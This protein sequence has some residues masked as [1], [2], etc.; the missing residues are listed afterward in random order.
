MRKKTTNIF[1]LSIV[2]GICLIAGIF[3]ACAKNLLDG[4]KLD[5]PDTAIE[6]ELGS[7]SLPSYHVVTADGA[8][9]SGY[10]VS[11]V[12]AKYKDGK[13]IAISYGSINVNTPATVEVV[14]ETDAEGVSAKTLTIEFD[15]RIAPALNFSGSFPQYYC[16]TVSYEIP[17]FT[18]DGNYDSAKTEYAIYCVD[19]EDANL[20]GAIPLWE[21]D[22]ALRFT[23]RPEDLHKFYA[24]T[25]HLEDE[26]GNTTN[27]VKMV[28]VN[29]PEV[30]DDN[31]LIYLEDPFGIN[32]VSDT[33]RGESILE[34]VSAS[35]AENYVDADKNEVNMQQVLSSKGIKGATKFTRNG[36]EEAFWT[37]TTPTIIDMGDNEYV[38]M[39]IYNPN[40]QALRLEHVRGTWYRLAPK[41]WTRVIMSKEQV[42]GVTDDNGTPQ[43]LTNTKF[44]VWD[45]E[46]GESIYL[47]N[48][49]LSKTLPVAVLNTGDA[50][51]ADSIIDTVHNATIASYVTTEDTYAAAALKAMGISGAVKV[52]SNVTS[53]QKG[54]TF[55]TLIRG[56]TTSMVNPITAGSGG[57][58]SYYG[59][60]YFDVYNPT[61]H[62]ATIDLV[63]KH[64]PV[65]LKSQEWTRVIY[66][67][68]DVD[69]VTD[70][71]G[72][73]DSLI[74][75]PD[76]KGCIKFC[77]EGLV[78]SESLYVSNFYLSDVNPMPVAWVD[79]GYE[80]ILI[81]GEKYDL[82]EYTSFG[83]T[84]DLHMYYLADR[85]AEPVD[86]SDIIRGSKFTVQDEHTSGIYRFVI[87]YT[88]AGE[89]Y[90][91]MRESEVV[92]SAPETLQGEG[93]LSK[94]VAD[95][96]TTFSVAA[97]KING[98]I[99]SITNQL[100]EV[101]SATQSEQD[102]KVVFTLGADD[103][104][105]IG[106]GD[107]ASVYV[108]T[109]KDG[110]KYT[111]IIKLTVWEDYITDANGLIAFE[112]A[113]NQATSA[114]APFTGWY[115]LASDID[116]TGIDH[117]FGDAAG[118]PDQKENLRYFA[119]VFD[120]CGYKIT[121]LKTGNRGLFNMVT[122]V[123]VIKNLAIVDAYA[124]GYNANGTAT[125]KNVSHG[126]NILAEKMEGTLE[127]LYVSGSVGSA[128]WSYSGL[129][130]QMRAE[131]I[132]N[133]IFK[134][135]L[136]GNVGDVDSEMGAWVQN[137]IAVCENVYI[138]SYGNKTFPSGLSDSR[139][140]IFAN[141][142]EC[143]LN[144]D[145][146]S[147]DPT[148]WSVKED[149][150]YFGTLKVLDSMRIELLE[151]NTDL[152]RDTDDNAASVSIEKS[153][154]QGNVTSITNAS[155]ETLQPVQS[156][157]DGMLVFTF[158][159]D[160]FAKLASGKQIIYINTES[161]GERH[162]YAVTVTVYEDYISTPDELI[163]FDTAF[164]ATGKGNTFAKNYKLSADIDL[165]DVDYIFGDLNTGNSNSASNV[166]F[167]GI[168][169]GQGHIIRGIKTGNS[170]MFGFVN[171]D[172]V[173]K[174][175]AVVDA[176]GQGD[177][178]ATIIG[179]GW[180]Q[181]SMENVYVSGVLEKCSSAQPGVFAQ[182]RAK[183]MK[184]V[185]FNVEK[186]EEDASDVLMGL[187]VM[188]NFANGEMIDTALENVIMI[189]SV[190]DKSIGWA[191]TSDR[192]TYDLYTS[193]ADFIATE[194]LKD[195]D[196]SVWEI[197]ADGVY[198]GNNKVL[199]I[200]A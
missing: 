58:T 164:L 126:S 175:L 182:N 108:R 77:V 78:A 130:W 148:I 132:R 167:G 68:E 186:A 73:P 100:G 154:L 178:C 16:P 31:T 66:T 113:L 54:Q 192:P 10:T 159:E 8:V 133:C 98:T 17:D 118:N 53:E 102:G 70:D 199:D 117:V 129:V 190:G 76:G 184:N 65:T 131:A 33:V 88:W 161:G 29:G 45:L 151:G 150:V 23:V 123:A 120:G 86:I 44:D 11:A 114:S 136:R 97:D 149:G 67:Y 80:Q 170:G 50:S 25:I 87:T 135:E 140:E 90:T 30:Y 40:D 47:A 158:G 21:G 38:Y 116:L 122:S 64:E 139:A 59:Y 9:L 147:F 166:I 84:A 60:L 187:W 71:N 162:S 1:V 74:G 96:K 69:K 41:A 4:A 49:K 185:I 191:G 168:F 27:F 52:T 13:E 55:F 189:S 56:E 51:S 89:D 143:A 95:N 127:N 79:G 63:W 177:F 104:K 176:R 134:V 42:D 91:L 165:T 28:E 110:T 153:I 36:H 14:Y 128:H 195:F 94:D 111:Y 145:F 35:E 181:G 124:Y 103:L 62:D 72:T 15:D 137:D 198:F 22:A 101:L 6:A 19:S 3:A 34:Y 32:Q 106:S 188:G 180:F 146:D 138:I 160:D 18:I 119:G 75:T 83:V 174:N 121:G 107:T 43:N 93:E 169:D 39:D 179:G 156:E 115:R 200:T 92:Q 5:V 46:L 85:D 20:E 183:S 173:I 155:G 7:Y 26:Y 61:D 196:S 2:M 82:P 193:E 157:A 105:K 109:E 12:S 112:T 125:E 163:A 24:V 171:R 99:L 142:S 37:L 57:K 152:S 194:D 48:V 144:A 81:T 172:G 197:K 141:G